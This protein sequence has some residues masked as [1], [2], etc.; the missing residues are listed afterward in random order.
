MKF[1]NLRAEFF[2][3][4]LVLCGCGP[5][6]KGVVVMPDGTRMEGMNIAVYTDPWSDSVVVR[7]DG[8]FTLSK[9]IQE[10][11]EYTLIA[12]DSQGNL[13][14]VRKYRLQKD[15]KENVVIRLSRE[16][17]AKDAVIEGSSYNIQDTGPG[18]KIFKSSQ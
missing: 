3:I 5:S 11:N 7:K 12:E 8:S 9:N 1:L 4:A 16:V 14:Y 17:E 2:L 18:E 6:I 10:K 15:K 13:G